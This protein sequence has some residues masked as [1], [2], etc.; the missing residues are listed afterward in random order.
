MAK[1]MT[2]IIIN[3]FYSRIFF[4][5]HGMVRHSFMLILYQGLQKWYQSG[6]NL[7]ILLT[8]GIDLSQ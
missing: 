6:E 4:F 8:V 7:L 2:C 3:N 1:V 5:F